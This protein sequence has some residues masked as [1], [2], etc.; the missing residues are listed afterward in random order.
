MY[1][2]RNGSISLLAPRH[3]RLQHADPII[4]RGD[5]RLDIAP[6]RLVLKRPARFLLDL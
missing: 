6:G 4:L 5:H 1:N 3:L 2:H